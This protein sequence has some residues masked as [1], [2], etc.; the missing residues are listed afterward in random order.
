MD[1]MHLYNRDSTVCTAERS[2][3]TAHS[4]FHAN[5]SAASH[6][7]DRHKICVL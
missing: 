6:M 7:A 2:N 4:A 3:Y 1:S 5:D